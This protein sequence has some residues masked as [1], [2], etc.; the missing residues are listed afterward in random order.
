MSAKRPKSHKTPKNSQKK[1]VFVLIFGKSTK[2]IWIFVVEHDHICDGA[3]FNP[4]IMLKSWFNQNLEGGIE[5]R[6][7]LF[8]RH[9]CQ[10]LPEKCLPKN[11]I[12]TLLKIPLLFDEF[13]KNEKF[14]TILLELFLSYPEIFFWPPETIWSLRNRIGKDSIFIFIQFG[15]LADIIAILSQRF[16][17]CCFI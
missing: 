13:Y 2:G 3:C 16:R 8:L 6:Y 1:F 4:Y 12:R 15:V 9:F 7:L 5:N 14:F 11:A 10:N 17:L